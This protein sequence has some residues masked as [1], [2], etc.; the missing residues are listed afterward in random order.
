VPT[1]TEG[2]D[3][4][5]LPQ[6]LKANGDYFSA[7]VYVRDYLPPYTHRFVEYALMGNNAEARANLGDPWEASDSF[8]LEVWSKAAYIQ[9]SEAA[10][11]PDTNGF[12]TLKEPDLGNPST[13][14]A[15]T[16][17]MVIPPMSKATPR[18]EGVV[19]LFTVGVENIRVHGSDTF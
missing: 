5:Y 3:Y 6:I 1:P 8:T 4:T 18:R 9:L 19:Q 14:M 2:S 11:D 15:Y 7:M 13:G 17:T 10:T 12:L 16:V